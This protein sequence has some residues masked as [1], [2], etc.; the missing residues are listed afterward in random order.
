MVEITDFPGLS[1]FDGSERGHVV[2]GGNSRGFDVSQ[3]RLFLADPNGDWR[4]GVRFRTIGNVDLAGGGLADATSHD[5]VTAVTGDRVLVMDQTAASENGIY[6]VPASGA[7]TRATD[8]DVDA[9]VLNGS[10]FYVFEGTLHARKAYIVTSSDP[11][12]VDTDD[13]TF[14]EHAPALGGAID[15]K[16][17]GSSVV[18]AA[19]SLDVL[20]GGSVSD[21]GGNIAGLTISGGGG[22]GGAGAGSS[23]LLG[24]ED[25]SAVTATSSIDI[26]GIQDTSGL[27]IEVADV[28]MVGGPHVVALE[29]STDGGSSWKTASG[30]Y[31]AEYYTR[32]NGTV[33]ENSGDFTE[34]FLTVPSAATNFAL[35]TL[36]GL[37][38]T[39]T[40]G[41]PNDSI[42]AG[43]CDTGFNSVNGNTVRS[44]AA[45][46]Y[47]G[48]G[49]VDAI[50]LV[51]SGGT[52]ISGRWAVFEQKL[53]AT[54][55]EY[56]KY[57]ITP[58]TFD[59]VGVQRLEFDIALHDPDSNLDTVTNPG[60]FTLDAVKFP[61]GTKVIFAFQFDWE[62][63]SA[64]QYCYHYFHIDGVKHS[65]LDGREA[66]SGII[67]GSS[68]IE[69]EITNTAHKYSIGSQSQSDVTVDVADTQLTVSV[70]EFQD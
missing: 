57:A 49:I 55:R 50:R 33:G 31:R 16:E 5:G 43:H 2:A 53:E 40:M 56:V 23:V 9:E 21:L 58:G 8:F 67:G 41:N 15:I 17:A 62:N 70:S 45:F 52:S 32:T 35:D 37:R 60:E 66:G 42:F 59:F 44:T 48:A 39:I 34:W 18:A 3:L 47:G 51:D 22:G 61:V 46:V 10:I 64:D 30:D 27:R 12:V 11:H 38:S 6:P 1:K 65:L 14:A 24:S 19:I 63:Y 54:G 4:D 13:I 25:F 68:Q 69:Y 26:S 29:V 7:A 20:S 28:G 36:S